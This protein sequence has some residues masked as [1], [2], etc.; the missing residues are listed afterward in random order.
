MADMSFAEPLTD[1]NS[2][3]NKSLQETSQCLQDYVATFY[4]YTVRSDIPRTLEDIKANGGDC[5]DYTKEDKGATGPLKDPARHF[6]NL[7]EVENDLN[8]AINRGKS[9][10]TFERLM[11]QGQDYF[12][13]RR[14]GYRWDP[15]K[16]LGHPPLPATF[17]TDSDLLMSMKSCS[18]K[19]LAPSPINIHYFRRLRFRSN[20]N[21]TK[22]F[23]FK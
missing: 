2:C 13:H 20:H 18:E 23:R 6:R 9:L 12:S 21:L 10:D 14:K 16:N 5:Y 11:H 17:G 3:Q 1:I 15:P 4:N 19:I 22:H 8:D 7:G